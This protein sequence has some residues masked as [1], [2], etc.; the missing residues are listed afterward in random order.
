LGSNV[1]IELI[2]KLFKIYIRKGPKGLVCIDDIGKSELLDTPCL[3]LWYL[4]TRPLSNALLL[5]R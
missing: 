2:E 4:L 5:L 3:T 1:R